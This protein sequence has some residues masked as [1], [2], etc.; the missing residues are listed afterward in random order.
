MFTI[1]A[2]A[3][4][5]W[6]HVLGGAGQMQ[7][8]GMAPAVWLTVL[9]FPVVS[10]A[11]GTTFAH[12]SAESTFATVAGG[13]LIAHMAMAAAPWAFGLHVHTAVDTLTGTMALLHLAIAVVLTTLVLRGDRALGA[14]LAAVRTVARMLR[15]RTRGVRTALHR[16]AIPALRTPAAV[17]GTVHAG[18]GPPA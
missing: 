15:V 3:G 8:N 9:V 6:A 18:R 16:V 14:A 4:A 5:L 12:R 13:Q 1:A 11:R 17:P 7:F 10:A 2:M